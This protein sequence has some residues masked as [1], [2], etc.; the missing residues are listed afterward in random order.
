MKSGA[1]GVISVRHVGDDRFSIDIRGHV[2]HVDQ[3]VY[4][5]GTDTAPTPTELFVAGL[6]SCI[7]FYGRRYLAHHDIA[8][9]GFE[10]TAAY[11]MADRPARVTTVDVRITAPPALPGDRRAALLAV[12]SRCTVHN[13]LA[14]PPDVR[15]QFAAPLP[16]AV[17]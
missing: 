4:A 6:A 8:A 2:V 5:G 14:D 10:V 12:A 11:G 7:A 13:S 17:H 9:E 1:P 15:V 3:P 16:A